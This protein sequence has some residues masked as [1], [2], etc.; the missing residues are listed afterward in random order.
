MTTL[1]SRIMKAAEFDRGNYAGL[2]IHAQNSAAKEYKRLR[3]LIEALAECAEACRC[4]AIN[5][6]RTDIMEQ[7]T[8]ALANLESVVGK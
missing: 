8:K 6:K 1:K 2:I 4:N 3:P 5:P 7:S